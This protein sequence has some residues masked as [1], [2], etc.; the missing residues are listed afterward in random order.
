MVNGVMPSGTG[1][2]H[3]LKGYSVTPKKISKLAEKFDLSHE[4]VDMFHNCTG[5]IMKAHPSSNQQ[6]C[7]WCKVHK[8]AYYCAGCKRWLCFD[9]R[10]TASTN[11]KQLKL[12]SHNI[13]G[14]K[15]NFQKTCYHEAHKE[16][17]K[18]S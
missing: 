4:I 7:N 2:G 8:T 13:K 10:C 1:F 12:Y 5:M 9:R 18:R 16:A 17:W 6:R 14:K 11:K 15:I 3:V